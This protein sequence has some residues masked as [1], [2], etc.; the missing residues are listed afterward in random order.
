MGESIDTSRLK[1]IF[2]SLFPHE[3]VQV[4]SG[5]VQENE[6]T[7][8]LLDHSQ[9]AEVNLCQQEVI[10]ISLSSR[11]RGVTGSEGVTNSFL[12]YC[13]IPRAEINY[14]IIMVLHEG[15]FLEVGVY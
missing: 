1:L 6:K 3:I 14:C 10:Q 2:S 13:V 11:D 15:V 12:W 8:V 7:A 5:A 9:G 4:V